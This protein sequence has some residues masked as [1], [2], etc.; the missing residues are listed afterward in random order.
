MQDH[1]TIFEPGQEVESFLAYFKPT[2][3]RIAYRVYYRYSQYRSLDLQD[4]EQVGMIRAWQAFQ[5]LL[6]NG[7][8]SERAAWSFCVKHAMGGMLG[9]VLRGDRVNA[10]SLEA[11]LAPQDDDGP[12]RELA[13]SNSSATHLSS[14]AMRRATLKTLRTSL[15]QQERLVLM[16]TYAID[17]DKTGKALTREE[18]MRQFPMSAKAWRETKYRALKKLRTLAG[19]SAQ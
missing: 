7:I 4:L 2:V 1:F 5:K 6:Q 18:V 19:E 17:D 12:I 9:F 14:L 10:L 15:S 3:T 11:Y 16:A 8:S 13:S